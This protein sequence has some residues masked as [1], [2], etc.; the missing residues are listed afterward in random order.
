MRKVLAV[1]LAL[2]IL[3]AG[4]STESLPPKLLPES[5]FLA[6][7]QRNYPDWS[8]RVSTRYGSGRYE[9]EMAQYAEVSLYRITDE[10]IEL[11]EL[12]ALV[13]PI[14]EGDDVP[15][16]V[17]ALIPVE[18][19]PGAADTLR[20][21][22]AKEIF[23]YGVGA[24]FTDAARNL[25]V[26]SLRAADE[27]VT[28]LMSCSRFFFCI[29]ENSAGQSILR[30]AQWDG[31]GYTNV[32]ATLPQPH[33]SFNTSHSYN[34]HMELW[35][36]A[37]DWV[38]PRYDAEVGWHINH[39]FINDTYLVVFQNRII[40]GEI[41]EWYQDN[42]SEHYGRFTLPHS[43]T[44]VDFATFPQTLDE[45][46]SH[47]DYTGVACTAHDGTPLYATS[48][49]D[50][51][52]YCYTRVPMVVI[53]ESGDWRE[54]QLGGD[55]DGLRCWVRA[56][57]LAFGADTENVVCTFPTHEEVDE[58]QEAVSF[59]GK[60]LPL[61]KGCAWWMIGTMADG[62]YLMMF[63][64][65]EEI[66]VGTAL[67]SAFSELGQTED[68]DDWDDEGWDDDWDDEEATEWDDAV[69]AGIG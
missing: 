40:E 46:L 17:H 28:Q 30:L 18:I 20:A 47:M 44:E 7:I 27:T 43:L 29:T 60:A 63:A 8:V 52:A 22:T 62:D 6:D 13:N 53:S 21:M 4:A 32:T 15:W 26:P 69:D 25:L 36:N 37:D 33:L 3:C 41:E 16:S 42:N 31:S 5:Y 68:D 64:D 23:D 59:S 2:L 51:L 35:V 65:N 19:V 67:P 66:F 1:F 50:V 61:A 57:D 39:F 58:A 38:Y 12:T 45:V 10:A 14:R 24:A 55:A 9:G 11:L 49:G 56:A 54:V 34:D 48:D